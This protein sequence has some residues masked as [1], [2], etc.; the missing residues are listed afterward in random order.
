[1]T[2]ISVPTNKWS[3]FQ[4]PVLRMFKNIQK[5]VSE[6][7]HSAPTLPPLYCSHFISW[8]LMAFWHAHPIEAW[9]LKCEW[10]ARFFHKFNF[11]ARSAKKFGINLRNFLWMLCTPLVTSVKCEHC[12][13][14]L[15][16]LLKIN[17][18][19]SWNFHN[20]LCVIVEV[21]YKI[22]FSLP[23]DKCTAIKFQ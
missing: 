8:S 21:L 5:V 11:F 1:M 13:K 17:L 15:F 16:L 19:I 18:L 10:Q 7:F 2:F 22:W 20:N 3:I 6:K 4:I 9:E 14:N 12:C 23:H